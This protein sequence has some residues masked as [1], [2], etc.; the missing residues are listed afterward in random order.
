MVCVILAKYIL[1]CPDESRQETEWVSFKDLRRNSHF[2]NVNY[3]ASDTESTTAKHFE[4]RLDELF[5]A[6]EAMGGIPCKTEI[7]Y[8]LSMQFAALPRVSLLLLFN[9]GD[10]E[11]PAQC[12]VLFQKSAEFF[13]D[14]ESLAMT[15]AWLARN[16]KRLC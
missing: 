11:F 12:S 10:E 15:G 6:S 1:L 13:L 14:P 8:D 16:L 5:K 3:F 7:S 4:G 2:L 9:D